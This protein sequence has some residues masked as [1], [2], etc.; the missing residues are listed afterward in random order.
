MGMPKGKG[1]VAV[2]AATVVALAIG[3]GIGVGIRES[4]GFKKSELSETGTI[5]QPPVKPTTQPAKTQP[6]VHDEVADEKER[7]KHHKT[8]VEELKADNIRKTLE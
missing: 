1:L 8:I 7:F 6:P 4:I 5:K 3:I 2:I